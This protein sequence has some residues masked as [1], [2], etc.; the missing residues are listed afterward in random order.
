MNPVHLLGIGGIGMSALA[1]ILKKRGII[2][3][4]SDCIAGQM[5][6]ALESEGIPVHIGDEQIPEHVTV[7]YSS[8][9]CPDHPKRRGGAIHRSELLAQLIQGYDVMAVAG[10]HGK[11]TTAALLTWVF[12]TVGYDPSYALGG[13]LKNVNGH[14]GDGSEFIIEADES[15]GSF[16]N[17]HP[18]TIILTSTD[19]DHLNFWKTAEALEQ[20]YL[21][22]ASRAKICY[23]CLDDVHIPVKGVSYGFHPDSDYC[24]THYD[25]GTMNLRVE[26]HTYKNIKLNLIGQHNAR[27]AAGVFALA[28][29]LGI[30]DADI[31]KAFKT[32]PGVSRRQ[33]VVGDKQGIRIID[34]YAHHPVEIAATLHAL[35]EHYPDRRLVALFQPHRHTR[36]KDH[37]ADF[38][39]C[40]MQA[41]QTFITETYSAG[42][43]PIAGACAQQLAEKA[44]A[45]FLY[46]P[47]HILDYLRPHDLLVTLGAGD[48]THIGKKLLNENFPKLNIGLLYGGK[49]AE[50]DISK[51]S[52]EAITTHLDPSQYNIKQFYIEKTGCINA[53]M[54]SGLQLCDV[55]FPVFHGPFGE[56]GSIQGLLESL[57]LPY[58]GC[59]Y[60]SSAVCMD[61]IWSKQLAMAVNIP[62][63]PF[64]DFYAHEWR[65]NPESILENIQNLTYP[66]WLKS[67]HL[68]SSIGVY[69]IKHLDDL[70]A[71]IEKALAYDERFL[72]EED[73]HGRE[74]EV[75]VLGGDELII[76]S[77][78]EILTDGHFYDYDK[79]YSTAAMPTTTTPELPDALKTQ[80]HEYSLRAFRALGCY[81]M[82]RLD[83]LWNEDKGLIFSEANPIPGFTPISLY[84]KLMEQMGITYPQLLSRL[85]GLALA[86][87][88]SHAQT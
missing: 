7:A 74:F 49:S 46:H 2:V 50:H 57:N 29:Q 73:F 16:L 36:L 30:H 31:Y 6:R 82:V 45:H 62:V 55:V 26:G 28:H 84:P 78:G 67:A 10:T 52:A 65:K 83:Y 41:D 5:T 87:K 64:I 86:K 32:F 68:G 47:D 44:K 37:F 4:G 12:Q 42:E 24:I 43:S 51:I 71:T 38:A 56:D 70:T 76:S 18:Q 17:Y 85:I 48:I 88:K 27:N 23:F 66:L 75:A 39:T 13:L 72:I 40:F 8:A 3:S 22:F 15:D 54:L 14:Q 81:G 34:D 9:I 80:M 63:A 59:D 35:R 53:S 25:R 58:V 60:R 61:K 20:A 1:R 21:T 77:P 69:P 79:K 33:E 19:A 11:T